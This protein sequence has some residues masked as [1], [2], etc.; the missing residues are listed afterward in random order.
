MPFQACRDLVEDER[1]DGDGSGGVGLRGAKYGM[2]IHLG[3]AFDD[4]ESSLDQVDVADPQGREFAESESGVGQDPDCE[5][6]V[7]GGVR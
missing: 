2:P 6:V 1:R 4:L 5:A 3:D 7:T